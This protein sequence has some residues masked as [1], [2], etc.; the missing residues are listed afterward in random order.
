MIR[1]LP[2]PLTA[3]EEMTDPKELAR[4][5]AHREEFDRNWAWLKQHATEIYTRHR[6]KYVVVA[7]ERSFVGDTAEEAWAQVAE[8][9]IQEK[10]SFVMRVPIRESGAPK[11]PPPVM[12]VDITDPDDLARADAQDERFGRNLA[13]FQKHGGEISA[14]YRGRW[15]CIAGQELFAADTA[16]DVIALARAAHPDDDGQFTYC[17]PRER[18]ARIYAY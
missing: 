2:S 6:G 13:W 16:R 17:V 1:V 15:I 8:A 10:G 12:V 3:I 7:A 9:R 14:Q 18:A 11:I 4:A 5:Q